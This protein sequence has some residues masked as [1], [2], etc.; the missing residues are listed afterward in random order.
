MDVGVR[1]VGVGSNTLLICLGLNRLGEQ[2]LL[3]F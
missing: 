3:D 1:Y 2:R